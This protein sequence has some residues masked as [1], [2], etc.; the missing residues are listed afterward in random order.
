MTREHRTSRGCD[1]DPARGGSSKT[2]HGY[3]LENDGEDGAGSDMS[4]CYTKRPKNP[5]TVMREK[6]NTKSSNK[7]RDR[8][9]ILRDLHASYQDGGVHS[10]NLTVQ[11]LLDIR[12]ILSEISSK[13]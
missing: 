6:Y 12:E 1:R 9:D 4:H 2:K 8:K 3:N 5:L 10:S 11:I 7:M 13:I